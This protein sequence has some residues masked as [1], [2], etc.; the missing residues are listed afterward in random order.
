MACH[1]ISCDVSADMCECEYVGE[2]EHWA[3]ASVITKP[4]RDT[5]ASILLNIYCCWRV[6]LS[7]YIGENDKE[8]D[9]RPFHNNIFQCLLL[10][11]S[12]FASI[13][14][15]L[16]YLN[17]HSN[18]YKI[19]FESINN[20]NTLLGNRLSIWNSTIH[21]C[22]RPNR[23]FCT[24]SG[25]LKLGIFTPGNTFTPFL[26]IP[27]QNISIFVEFICFITMRKLWHLNSNGSLSLRLP[28]P[29]NEHKKF[30]Q[31]SFRRKK[32]YG[33]SK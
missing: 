23:Y 8:N 24:T 29:E 30:L 9:E 26:S 4:I 28:F 2:P 15:Y 25:T 32:M 31:N 1:C 21:N 10:S 14:S 27:L 16:G 3:S 19:L 22:M 17:S 20:L 11:I 7:R 5:C 12:S 18:E 6:R 33:S 13:Y